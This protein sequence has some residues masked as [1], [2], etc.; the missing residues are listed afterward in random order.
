MSPPPSKDS[1]MREQRRRR[2]WLPGDWC[3]DSQRL[4]R[5]GP[6][7]A[8]ATRFR[9]R[10]FRSGVSGLG[11]THSVTLSDETV[12]HSAWLTPGV[13]GIGTASFLADLGHEVPTALL[14]SL[15]TTTLG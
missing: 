10:N 4:M 12:D 13:R 3:L 5:D 14:P 11:N 6:S 7:P 1:P 8:P 15:L 9:T 2:K